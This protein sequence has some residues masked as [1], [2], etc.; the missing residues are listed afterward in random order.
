MAWVLHLCHVAPGSTAAMAPF[1][2]SWASETTSCTP[3][4]PRATR[5]RRNAVHPAPSSTVITSTPSTSRFPSAFTPVAS[6]TATFCTRPSSRTR[7]TRASTH[8]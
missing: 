3:D 5:P 1:N 2:P 8:T 7:W 6:T 4:R